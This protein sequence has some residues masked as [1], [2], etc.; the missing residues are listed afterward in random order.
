[1]AESARRILIL[2]LDGLDGGL[3]HPAIDAG[4]LP[5]FASLL[6]R[7]A[8]GDLVASGPLDP[9]VAWTTL[10]SGHRPERHRVLDSN[11]FDATSGDLRP[12]GSDARAV[13]AIWNLAHR[14]DRSS[15]CVGWP[16]SDPADPIR[17]GF[18]S[19]RFFELAAPIDAPWPVRERSLYPPDLASSLADLRLHPDELGA[20]ELAPF[21]AEPIESDP[22]RDARPALVMEALADTVSRHAVA[23]HLLE[24]EEWSLAAI[25]YPLLDRL[26]RWFLR[27]RPPG[28]EGV[29]QADLRRYGGVLDASMRLLDGMLARLVQIAGESTTVIVASP[30]GLRCGM[31]RPSPTSAP[32]DEAPGRWRRERGVLALAGPEIAADRLLH[33]AEDLDVVP[34]AL[35]SAGLPIGRDMPGRVRAEAFATSPRLEWIESWE[36]EDLPADAFGGR[37]DEDV[38]TEFESDAALRQLIDLGYVEDPRLGER[39]ERDQQVREDFNLAVSM[40]RAREWRKAIEPLERVAAARA[41]E[42]GCLLLLATCHLSAGDA[43]ATRRCAERARLADDRTSAVVELL[44]AGAAHTERRPR[45]E[46]LDHVRAADL[47]GGPE[48]ADRL[49]YAYVLLRRHEDAE[50]VL[51]AA[52]HVEDAASPL[53]LLVR[54]ILELERGDAES[55]A[56]TALEAIGRRHHWPEAHATLG[57]ALA[58]MGR[59]AEARIALERSIEQRPTARAHR[60]L[61]SL[62]ERTE[63]D[64]EG[65][66]RHRAQAEAI[67][68]ATASRSRSETP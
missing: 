34:T 13:R 56:T 38:E 20:E 44:L 14:Q 45:R 40:V 64:A 10:L 9:A 36:A 12:T 24:H 27:Y 28:L 4:T 32:R 31:D 41:A 50:R 3:L 8:A 2:G 46:I 47:A 11:A 68:A 21:V 15:V 39:I 59:H 37:E 16:A 65:A 55:A 25:R 17:G 30:F 29:E 60:A 61:A 33:G 53:R 54:S 22:T 62:L 58:A 5:A 43:E 63:W 26:G 67:D 7:G 49:A 42:A 6:E 57:I 1:M 51:D 48:I 18:V 19:E 52:N 23:T 35:A 66:R